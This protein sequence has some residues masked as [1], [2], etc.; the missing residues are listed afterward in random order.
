MQVL[1]SNNL[2]Y[3]TGRGVMIQMS[4]EISLPQR[5]KTTTIA[6]VFIS[7]IHLGSHQT[8]AHADLL[9]VVRSMCYWESARKQR[10][11]HSHAIPNLDTL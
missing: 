10:R 2:K 11:I 8:F 5:A 4:I 7:N 1:P 9:S 3:T 6:T